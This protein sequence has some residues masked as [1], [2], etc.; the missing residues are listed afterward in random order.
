[1]SGIEFIEAGGAEALR[2]QNS[3]LVAIVIFQAIIIILLIIQLRIS[4][5]K[6]LIRDTVADAMRRGGWEPLSAC[7]RSGGEYPTRR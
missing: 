7:V 1:M 5:Q 2:S 3:I 6:K 4:R